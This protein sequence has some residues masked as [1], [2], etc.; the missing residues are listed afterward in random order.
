M[1]KGT[2]PF[3]TLSGE[4]RHINILQGIRDAA[5][6]ML[7]LIY[8]DPIY[9]I[10]CGNIIDET[11]TYGL[12]DHCVR[13]MMWDK[14]GPR[15]IDGMDVMRC[16]QYGIYE[17]TL[18]FSLKYDGKRYIARHIAEMMRDK[19]KYE[20]RDRCYDVIVPVPLYKGKERKRGFNQTAL[21]GKYLAA[22]LGI[23]C[24]PEALLRVRET[25]PMR[26]LSPQ[27]RADNI[28]GCFALND[29]S[30]DMLAGERVLLLDDFYT[31]GATAMECRRELMR[32]APAEISLLAFAA[33]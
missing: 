23:M 17:R 19:L 26:G 4:V 7:D 28:A 16:C 13:H 1:L 18:I 22:Q 8:P 30:E 14:S 29:M 15:V 11:R 20:N 24:M 27:E 3:D 12:C 10:C 21:I 2:V 25:R 9:C 31:T 33:K 32:A 6:K 5:D